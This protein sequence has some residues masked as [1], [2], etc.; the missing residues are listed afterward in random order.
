MQQAVTDTPAVQAV[1]PSRVRYGR[2]E[3]CATSRQ[4]FWKGQAVRLTASEFKVVELLARTG[5]YV[6]QRE[7]YETVRGPGFHAGNGPDGYRINVRT[8]LRRIRQ[9]FIALDPRFD[10]IKTV[11]DVRYGYQWDSGR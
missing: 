7:V 2:L 9:K 5:G 1:P 8:M 3:I 11:T 6:S 10:G 4:A